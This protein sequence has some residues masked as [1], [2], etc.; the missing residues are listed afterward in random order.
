MPKT[1]TEMGQAMKISA[2]C[3]ILSNNLP[4][5]HISYNYSIKS[6]GNQSEDWES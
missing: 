1:G 5:N 2:H 4:N 3:A 6:S